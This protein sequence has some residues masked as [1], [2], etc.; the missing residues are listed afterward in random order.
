M[1]QTKL[2][3][4]YDQLTDEEKARFWQLNQEFL[5]QQLAAQKRRRKIMKAR[6]EK[7]HEHDPESIQ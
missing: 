3:L 5:G 6:Q 4:M 2:R 1:A 7:E